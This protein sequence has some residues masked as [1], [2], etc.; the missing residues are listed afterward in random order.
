MFELARSL[1]ALPLSISLDPATQICRPSPQPSLNAQMIKHMGESAKLAAIPFETDRRPFNTSAASVT[2]S[3]TA[4][5]EGTFALAVESCPSGPS[6]AMSR[7]A[8][9]LYGR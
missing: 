5:P 2:R 9:A 6:G 8:A 4:R 1:S 3:S 7:A